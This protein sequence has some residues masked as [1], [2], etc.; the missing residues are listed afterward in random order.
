MKF[1]VFIFL[2]Y[3]PFHL[4]VYPLSLIQS[5]LY[6]LYSLA[7][8]SF[9]NYLFE[10][11]PRLFFLIRLP[12]KEVFCYFTFLVLIVGACECPSIDESFVCLSSVICLFIF[13]VHIS[14]GLLELIRVSYCGCR[15]FSWNILIELSFTL[16]LCLC[17]VLCCCSFWAVVLVHLLLH[18][19]FIII[20]ISVFS[21]T[22]SGLSVF[23]KVLPMPRFWKLNWEIT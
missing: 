16:H 12:Q 14:A 8:W 6:L 3:Y 18:R 22:M 11:S 2:K 5:L 15:F 4:L 19:T 13:F 23:W 9:L 20:W 10:F 7:F 21:F 17:E 1:I